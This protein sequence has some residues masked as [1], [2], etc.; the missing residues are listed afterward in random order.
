MEILLSGAA[1]M[2]PT[3]PGFRR[4]SGTVAS[5]LSNLTRLLLKDDESDAERAR[6]VT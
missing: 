1:P 5:P 3:T 2:T 4:E 6:F